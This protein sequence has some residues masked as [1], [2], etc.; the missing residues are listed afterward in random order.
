MLTT[1]SLWARLVRRV[2]P[3]QGARRQLQEAEERYRQLV[4]QLPLV[5]YIDALTATASSMYMSPQVEALLDYPAEIWLQDPEFFAKILH[6]GDRER[7]LALVDHCNNTADPFRADYRL[8]AQDGRTVWVQ[9]ESL[10]QRDADGRPS[11][12]Q[13]YL[14]DITHRK[15]AEQRLNAEHGV[16]RVL[17]E[18]GSLEEVTRRIIELVC[19][20]FGWESGSLWVLDRESGS[21]RA[22]H[23]G[24]HSGGWSDALA[25]QVQLAGAAV[26]APDAGVPSYA[27][28]IRAGEDL[29]G[30]LAF[31]LETRRSPAPALIRT[32][33]VIASQIGQFLDR[34]QSEHAVRESE[35]RK[36][37]ILDS[38]LD[39]VITVDHEGRVI[40]F[41]PA[42]ERAFGRPLAEVRGRRMADLCIPERL[43]DAHDDAFRRCIEAGQSSLLGRRME[44]EAIRADGTE[45]PIELTVVRVDLPGPPMLTA[46][47][48]DITDRKAA[49][50]GRARAETELR[51]LALHDGLTGLP[52]RSL[53]HD[54]VTQAL[55]RSRRS[56]AAFCVLL[57]DLDRFKE[58]NDTLGHHTGDALLRELGERLQA[59]VRAVRHGRAARRRRVR[60]PAQRRH[61]VGGARGRRPHPGRP[62]PSRSRYSGSLLEVEASVGIALF[63]EHG[64]GVDLLLQRADV[65][66]YAAK[67]TARP[68]R[69]LRPA[70][71]RPHARPPDHGRRPA[72][73]GRGAASCVLHYQPQ[74]D[75]ATG[76]V[77]GVRGAACAGSTPSVGLLGPGRVRPV[78]ERSGLMHSLTRYVARR[79]APPARRMAPLRAAS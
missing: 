26:W 47:A 54:R 71:G 39:C 37:A 57:M 43:R 67:R 8:I 16:A 50:E 78:A 59:C 72:P 65:A 30:V 51:H 52:N 25:A 58:V 20:A 53:F 79:G 64:D 4:E 17:A 44:T 10:V 60:L 49:E 31:Q 11:F 19:E 66:M 62:S 48:R 77:T 14:L 2:F 35:A 32:I 24:A 28:P 46:Y 55:E 15:E 42:A 5:T 56:G 13:G 74:V 75:L 22:S 1:P 61:G 38:A 40:E 63:P 76:E 27:A 21:L 3:G 70:G 34:K 36:R 69:V 29:V 33:A 68:V 18:S 7:V 12:T 41:N 6:P 9:D 23:H 45:F 73:R